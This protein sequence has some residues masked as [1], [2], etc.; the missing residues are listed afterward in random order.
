MRQ[1]SHLPRD[2]KCK[3]E[4]HAGLRKH[5]DVSLR[6]KQTSKLQKRSEKGLQSPK[7]PKGSPVPDPAGDKFHWPPPAGAHH[8]EAQGEPTLSQGPRPGP[9]ATQEGHSTTESWGP[10]HS[11]VTAAKR[12]PTGRHQAGSAT[13]ADPSTKAGQA[14]P[15]QAVLPGSHAP[16]GRKTPKALGYKV[17]GSTARLDHRMAPPGSTPHNPLQQERSGLLQ[18]A[19]SSVQQPVRAECATSRQAGR[20]PISSPL[21]GPRD[22]RQSDFRGGRRHCPNL[23]VSWPG[24]GEHY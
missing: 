23:Q 1:V 10:P 22:R 19:H 6:N 7:G 4:S 20:L 18:R 2:A 8:Q 9:P 11:K 16:Q 5:R 17:A 13:A 3:T 14:S 15:P 21:P 12:A 24:R